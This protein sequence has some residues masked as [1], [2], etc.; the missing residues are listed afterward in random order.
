MSKHKA[1]A[2]VTFCSG[3]THTE[4]GPKITDQEITEAPAHVQGNWDKDKGVLTAGLMFDGKPPEG[5]PAGA[6]PT[7]LVLEYKPKGGKWTGIWTGTH[8]C[9]HT[10]EVA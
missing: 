5:V 3:H 1:R 7:E 10:E 2:R 8:T 4:K 9:S 6:H